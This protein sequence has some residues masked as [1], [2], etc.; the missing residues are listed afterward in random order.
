MKWKGIS[1]M[2]LVEFPPKVKLDKG[3]LYDNIPMD[4]VDGGN[5]SVAE[6]LKKLYSGG[7]TR[8]RME[9]QF[10]HHS[11]FGEWKNSKGKRFRKKKMDSVQQSFLFFA[12]K[13][14]YRLLFTI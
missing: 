10:Y 7:R 8:F 13:K 2:E 1:F 5:E 3:E 4:A 6:M 14:I 12:Q 11:L 9:I